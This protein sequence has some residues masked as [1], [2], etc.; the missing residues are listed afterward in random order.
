MQVYAGIEFNHFFLWVHTCV[1][2]Y[3]EAIVGGKIHDWVWLWQPN[4]VT[5]AEYFNPKQPILPAYS[6]KQGDLI[7]RLPEG[8]TVR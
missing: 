4:L 5:G 7:L 8:K 6:G 3:P 2:I 1:A